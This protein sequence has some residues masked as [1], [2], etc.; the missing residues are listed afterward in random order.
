MSRRARVATFMAL[1]LVVLCGVTAYAVASAV[2]YHRTH[3][4]PPT[5]ATVTD[6][7]AV[8]A[9]S[10]PR[11]LFRHTGID[12][13]YG[14][15][16]VVS[17]VD[18]GGARAFTPV[19][20]D[21]VYATSEVESCLRTERGVVTEY[22]LTEYDDRWHQ[23]QQVPVPGIPSRTRLSPD[24]SLVATTTFV[25][26]HSYMQ[27]GFST[28]TEIRD[29][30]GDSHGDLEKFDLVLLGRHV[31]PRDRNVWGVTFGPDDNTFYATV[32]TGGETYLVRGDL[33]ARTLTSVADDVEC[34]SLSPDG[35]RIAFK[36]ASRRDGRT[37]WT[38]AVL[39]LAHG[40]RTVLSGETR[41]VDDQIEWLDRDTVLYGVGRE[42]EPGVS[43]VWELDTSSDARPRLLIEQAWS[44]AVVR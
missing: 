18:P 36:Q 41:D 5:V 43:D 20:C 6:D 44:P 15:V 35:T 42:D 10:E 29:V 23:L 14:R 11:I 12:E 16:A 33:R 25:S 27:V 21:R 2:R 38:P 26:G 13:R 37:W 8:D 32:G 17:L 31:V 34:P 30:D 3:D 39:D 40:R 19:S 7:A 22:S 24:G 28:A 9:M 1:A 4:R